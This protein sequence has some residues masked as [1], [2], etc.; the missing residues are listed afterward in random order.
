MFTD[1]QCASDILCN[2]VQ[3]DNYLLHNSSSVAPMMDNWISNLELGSTDPRYD[4]SENILELIT[5][6]G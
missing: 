3:N 5:N 6:V 1:G 4:W 2:M